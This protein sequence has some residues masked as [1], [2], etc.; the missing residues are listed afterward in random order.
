[1]LLARIPLYFAVWLLIPLSNLS[2]EWTITANTKHDTQYIDRNSL[3]IKGEIR[4]IWGLS[5][6]KKDDQKT[7]VNSARY[8]KEINCKQAKE[9]LLSFIV[10]SEQMG[11]GDALAVAPMKTWRTVPENTAAM[12]TLKFVCAL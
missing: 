8:L 6:Y 2:A 10:Y 11:L 3:L 5:D 1:M 9:R 7:K 12:M 4:R